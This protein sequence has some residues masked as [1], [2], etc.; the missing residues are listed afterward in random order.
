MFLVSSKTLVITIKR[1]PRSRNYLDFVHLYLRIARPNIS[2]VRT[3]FG[4]G[5]DRVRKRCR[6]I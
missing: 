3:C 5:P 4:M 2:F 6:G 1:T